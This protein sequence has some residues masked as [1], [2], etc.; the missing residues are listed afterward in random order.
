A[1]DKFDRDPRRDA[2]AIQRCKV[3]YK[4]TLLP[5]VSSKVESDSS[6][7]RPSH[8]IGGETPSF[9]GRVFAMPLSVAGDM[10][11]VVRYGCQD[12][13]AKARGWAAPA[14]LGGGLPAPPR[15]ASAH[16]E[17]SSCSGTV[18]HR[19]PSGGRC[20]EA[21]SRP[22]PELAGPFRPGNRR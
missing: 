1:Q 7:N 12:F 4:S 19:R 10:P 16:A 9:K 6:R 17:S 21:A 2:S 13:S 11:V 8:V 14:A 5:L 22:G 3:K 15:S 18:G 20:A